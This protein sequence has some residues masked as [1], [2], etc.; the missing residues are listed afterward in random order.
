[1][2]YKNVQIIVRAKTGQLILE[3]F[4]YW[5]RPIKEEGMSSQS[6][7]KVSYIYLLR[8]YFRNV[9]TR[10]VTEGRRTLA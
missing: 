7:F 9:Y 4:E 2:E 3:E 8:H 5:H 6:L 10:G 1:M